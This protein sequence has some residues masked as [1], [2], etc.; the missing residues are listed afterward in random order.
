MYSYTHNLQGDDVN[1]VDVSWFGASWA[2]FPPT[3]HGRERIMMGGGAVS[4]LEV[5]GNGGTKKSEVTTT[6]YNIN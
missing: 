5:R 4:L 3:L 6:L 1:A 2:Y